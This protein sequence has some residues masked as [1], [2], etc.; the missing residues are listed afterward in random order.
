MLAADPQQAGNDEHRQ[1]FCPIHRGVAFEAAAPDD[2]VGDDPES[3]AQMKEQREAQEGDKSEG[4]DGGHIQY[5]LM[6]NMIIL[7]RPCQG[8]PPAGPICPA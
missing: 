8:V 2:G 7:E 4:C 1:C 6:P 3:Y 5:Q